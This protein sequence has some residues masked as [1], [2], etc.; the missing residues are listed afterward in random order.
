MD[1]FLESAFAPEVL[2]H[3]ETRFLRYL[4]SGITFSVLSAANGYSGKPAKEMVV[5]YIMAKPNATKKQI[6]YDLNLS[7]VSVAK[8]LKELEETGCVAVSVSNKVKKYSV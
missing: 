8:A 5:N 7:Q 6:S 2:P 4:R 3:F 1:R